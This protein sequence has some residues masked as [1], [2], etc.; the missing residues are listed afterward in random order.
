MVKSFFFHFSQVFSLILGFF[1]TF[2]LF[3]NFYKLYPQLLEVDLPFTV[4]N[5]VVFGWWENKL[6]VVLLMSSCSDL[7]VNSYL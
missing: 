2:Y 4:G 1:V 6:V 5:P 3:F 7:T